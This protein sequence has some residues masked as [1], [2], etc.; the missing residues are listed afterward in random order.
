MR[1]KGRE[2]AM[3]DPALKRECDAA[4]L[5]FERHPRIVHADRLVQKLRDNPTRGH[6]WHTEAARALYED[7]T[8]TITDMEASDGAHDIDIQLDGAINI[9]TWYGQNVHGHVIS[10]QFTESG[11]ARNDKMGYV[12]PRGGTHSDF[13]Q[14]H[15]V[16]LKK[17]SQLPGDKLGI[18]LLRPEFIDFYIL[19]E[20][21]A[22]IP[23]NKCVINIGLAAG[24]ELCCSPDFLGEDDAR[25]IADILGAPVRDP[26][27]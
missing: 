14:D 8:Y 1:E 15:K 4:A 5:W 16:M 18:V 2:P 27:W 21:L 7:G 23:D 3:D 19:P 6:L 9:Q 20:W 26:P 10:G 17:L 11:R 13:D 22:D 25:A 12:T 24:T